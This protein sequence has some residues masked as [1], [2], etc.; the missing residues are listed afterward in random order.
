MIGQDPLWRA[1]GAAPA[2]ATLD[3]MSD[4]D[5]LTPWRRCIRACPRPQAERG[6][7]HSTQLD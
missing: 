6:H 7:E 3:T 4:P 2:S 5:P 1:K